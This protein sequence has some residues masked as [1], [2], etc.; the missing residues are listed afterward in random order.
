M[1]FF[2]VMP[3]MIGFADSP[4]HDRVARRS[5]SSFWLLPASSRCFSLF[6]E[7]RMPGVS[8]GPSTHLS[9]AIDVPTGGRFATW[10]LA[11]AS[12]SSAPSINTPSST[13]AP[14]MTL[15]KMPLFVVAIVTV[16]LLL[17]SMPGGGSSCRPQF[18]R[19]LTPRRRR[20]CSS[21]C[22]FFGHHPDRAGLRHVLEEA[23]RLLG[24]AMHGRDRRHQLMNH[25]GR[26][27]AVVFVATHGDR[28]ATGRIFSW[29]AT[30]L[31]ARSVERRC[32]AIGYLPARSAMHRLVLECRCRPL[33][34][35]TWPWWRYVLN[36]LLSSPAGTT[37][38][39]ITG[40]TDHQQ[41]HFWLICRRQRVH[42]L[43]IANAAASS[44]PSRMELCLVARRSCQRSARSHGVAHMPRR[45]RDNPWAR[46]G[47]NTVAAFHQYNELPL[48]N[49]IART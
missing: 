20:C 27:R 41:L 3:A 16:F 44:V 47:M 18:R 21:I 28:G 1:I 23:I 13:C 29:I 5:A 32:W 38:S 40:Y 46:P 31:G 35:G 10:P 11:G 14:G 25:L 39:E 45:R 34:Q 17:L 43:R 42:L 49:E 26:H 37:G 7:A 30:I 9:S 22:S 12:S 24:M 2:M 19:L 48:I 6:V 36:Y 33:A 8:G 4:A 15:H